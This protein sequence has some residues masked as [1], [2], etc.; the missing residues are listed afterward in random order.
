M[1]GIRSRS[2]RGGVNDNT[3][4]TYTLTLGRTDMKTKATKT[5]STPKLIFQKRA[6][7]SSKLPGNGSLEKFERF[8][9]RLAL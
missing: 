9:S 8:S 6:M 2:L 4:I 1:K 7:Y 5:F 3:S